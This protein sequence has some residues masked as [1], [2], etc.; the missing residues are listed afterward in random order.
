MYKS[1]NYNIE[2]TQKLNVHND[3]LCSGGVIFN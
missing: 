1:N 2:D 3:L